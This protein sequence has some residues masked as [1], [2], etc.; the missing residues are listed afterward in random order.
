MFTVFKKQQKSKKIR[1]DIKLLA[2]FDIHH[3]RED[4]ESNIEFCF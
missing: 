3:R 1:S 4:E 2:A